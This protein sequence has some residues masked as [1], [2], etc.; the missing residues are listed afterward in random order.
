MIQPRTK[1]ASLVLSASML[2]GIALH[3]DYTDHAVIPVPGDVPTIGFGATK[4]VKLGDMTTP[5]R[6]LARLLVDVNTHSDG[7]KNCITAPL[8]QYEF[9]AYSSL[10]F[11]IGVGAFCRSTLVAKLNSGDY[12][13]A[14][15]EI[16]KWDRFKGK[17]LRGLTKR[18]KA[19]YH[20]CM[21]E[22]T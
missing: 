11:N 4:N 6:A 14:C 1:I 19:E 21:G 9:D 16:L 20:L 22:T 5:P 3:E 15:H 8:Y 12:S 17:P 10:A 13:S 7:I 2:V 18:R